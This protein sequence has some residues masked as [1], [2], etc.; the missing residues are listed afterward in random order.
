MLCWQALPGSDWKKQYSK[1]QRLKARILYVDP[2]SKKIRLSL[3][4]ELLDLTL[5]RLAPVG[6]VFEVG[7]PC[8]LVVGIWVLRI[9]RYLGSS[10]G[11]Q[12]RLLLQ[13]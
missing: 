2:S 13:L 1:D 3:Q 10:H 9:A 6:Q 12:A 4:P 8:L 11:F 5:R 7:F